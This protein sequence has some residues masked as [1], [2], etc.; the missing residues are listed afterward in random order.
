MVA[1]WGENARRGRSSR[2]LRV[3]RGATRRRVVATVRLGR[4]NEPI[5]TS[6]RRREMVAIMYALL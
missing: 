3:E 4:E 1:E 5:P 6:G 2:G